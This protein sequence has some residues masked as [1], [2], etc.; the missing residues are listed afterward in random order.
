MNE[1]Y[2]NRFDTDHLHD[3]VISELQKIESILNSLNQFV[4]DKFNEYPELISYIQE[5]EDILTGLIKLYNESN[6]ITNEDLEHAYKQSSDFLA[7]FQSDTTCFDT[8]EVVEKIP[9][10]I[11]TEI[12]VDNNANCISNLSSIKTTTQPELLGK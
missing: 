4:R 9:L 7:E 10:K 8:E 11:H 6:K 5:L 12:D 1:L 3:T 2:K